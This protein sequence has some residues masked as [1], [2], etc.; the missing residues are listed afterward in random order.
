MKNR[1]S[2]G[3]TLRVHVG[4]YILTLL[5]LCPTWLVA[6]EAPKKIVIAHGNGWSTSAIVENKTA[7][8]QTVDFNTCGIGPSPY[9]VTVAPNGADK[10]SNIEVC[11]DW[12]AL[13]DDPPGLTI[14][15][16]LSYENGASR[17]SF[18]LP[19]F[20]AIDEAHPVTVGPVVVDDEEGG[21][22]TVF[23]AYEGTPIKLTLHDARHVESDLVE[24]FEAGE[25]TQYRIQHSGLFY[26]TVEI[27]FDPIGAFAGAP[28]FGF[29]STGTPAGGTFRPFSF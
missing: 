5:F 26:V 7:D 12:F 28:V 18:P 19:P 22:V 14:T 8:P 6:Q 23:A 4:L 29:A 27:G 20:G 11:G 10:V 16:I 15:S 2:D 1:H 3:A 13:I 21:W 25:I 17:A 9:F 24:T